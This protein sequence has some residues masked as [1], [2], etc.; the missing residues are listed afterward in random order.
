MLFSSDKLMLE[1][2]YVVCVPYELN[3]DF[4][5]QITDKNTQ[6]YS[7]IQKEPLLEVIFYVSHL[8]EN[9]I[10]F[11]LLKLTLIPFFYHSVH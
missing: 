8:N 5:L 1:F 7:D 6:I 11:K 10:I 4:I 3:I 2:N 9:F